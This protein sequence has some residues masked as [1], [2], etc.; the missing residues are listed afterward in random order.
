MQKLKFSRVEYWGA[1]CLLLYIGFSTLLNNF[2]V[3]AFGNLLF[4]FGLIGFSLMK[5][6]RRLA[7]L[8][9]TLALD[10]FLIARPVIDIITGFVRYLPMHYSLIQGQRANRMLALSMGSLFIGQIVYERILSKKEIERVRLYPSGDSRKVISWLSLAGLLVAL[11]ALLATIIE[12]IQYRQSH[13]YTA[14][15][16]DFSSAL[17]FVVQGF[18]AI[19]VTMVIMKL[20]TA[21]HRWSNWAVL[22]VYTGLNGMLMITGM[23]ANFTKTFLFALFLLLQRDLIPR[24]NRKYLLHVLIALLFTGGVLAGLFQQVEK[25]RSDYDRT[26]HF[27]LPVQFVYDQS[28]S[29]MA[30]ARGQEL[31]SVPMF[32]QKQYTVGPFLDQY[33]S[34]RHLEAYTREF[35][36]QGDSLAADIAFHLYGENAFKGYGLG[37][38][39]LIE[40]YSDYGYLGVILFSLALGI[41]LGSLSRISW[42]HLIVD[43]VKLRILLEIFYIPRAPA[44]Q[45][46]VN[47]TVPQFYLP[48]IG[49]LVFAY[50]VREYQK[51][52][53]LQ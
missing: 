44:V 24:F 30:L 17:P 38:S 52:S 42:H 45:F 15:Y 13:S 7:L 25:S 3:S 32:S 28:I 48:L 8:M 37:S 6:G 1:A 46:L 49:S 29:Y 26:S 23:R 50:A 31:K 39:Y 43:A 53:R 9:F 33:G 34:A 10:L 14:L 27:I 47:L 41:L 21:T 36:E 16:A 4:S 35:V 51:R 2:Y 11:A 40:V 22:A 19:A 12:K 18:A 20:V 5:P